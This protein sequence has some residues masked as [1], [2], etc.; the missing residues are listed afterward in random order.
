[1]QRSYKNNFDEQIVSKKLE[2]Y[3]LK[4]YCIFRNVFNK[5]ELTNLWSEI[6][7]KASIDK[8][9]R[10]HIYYEKDSNKIRRIEGLFD[11]IKEIKFYDAEIKELLKKIVD[12]PIIFKDKLNF[13]LPGIESGFKAHIDGHFYFPMEINKKIVNFEGWNYLSSRFINVLIPLLPMNDMNGCLELAD[14]SQTQKIL[15]RNFSDIT[16][17]LG[18]VSPFIPKNLEKY[19]NFEKIYVDIGDL[20]LFDWKC[21]HRSADNLSNNARPGFYLTYADSEDEDIR[22]KYYR[23]KLLSKNSSESKGLN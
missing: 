15:G 16:N 11:N 1:M 14:I 9:S 3:N 8:D 19:F 10:L 5:K 4:G 6:E 7:E 18:D 22:F 2:E 21:V 13:K 12:N 20:I 23:D 17:L